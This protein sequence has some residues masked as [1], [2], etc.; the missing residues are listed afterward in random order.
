[1]SVCR[2]LR[3][4]WQKPGTSENAHSHAIYFHEFLQVVIQVFDEV[5]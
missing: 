3:V 5:P 1:M 4:D 2:W